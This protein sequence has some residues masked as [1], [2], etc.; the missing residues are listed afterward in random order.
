MLTQKDKKKVRS[1]L[2]SIYKKILSKRNI[3]NCENKIIEIIKD[4]NKKNPK[5]EKKISE[6]TS[7]IICYGDN[8]YSNKKKSINVFDTFFK[9]KLEKYFNI[10]HFL[11]FYPSSSD[12]GFSV[13][14]HYKI[15][16]KLG[17]WS[18]IKR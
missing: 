8:V 4:F 2:N 18:D 14:D 5:R 16:N 3:D 7:L 13:K 9:K 15:D 1:K 11:P 12:S 17:N 6:K 10:I